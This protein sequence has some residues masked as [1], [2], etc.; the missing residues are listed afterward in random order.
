MPKSKLVIYF[1]SYE[2]REACFQQILQ[3]QGFANQIDQYRLHEVPVNKFRTEQQTVIGATH[4]IT[5]KSVAIKVLCAEKN[6][7]GD[8]E[9]GE[10]ELRQQLSMVKPVGIT[11]M[12][13]AI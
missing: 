5:K 12:I 10:L 11:K 1:A 3:Q 13:E 2:A 7:Q 4:L 9:N 8:L 6:A